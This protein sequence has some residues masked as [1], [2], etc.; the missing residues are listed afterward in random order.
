MSVGEDVNSHVFKTN[1]SKHLSDT[2]LKP[3]TARLELH[4]PLRARTPQLPTSDTP[5]FGGVFFFRGNG[6][7]GFINTQT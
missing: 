6:S 1:P 5:S 3:I 7:F 2:K 4:L